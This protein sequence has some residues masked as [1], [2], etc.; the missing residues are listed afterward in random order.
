MGF[1]F[2]RRI[3]KHGLKKALFA[4]LHKQESEGVRLL[5]YHSVDRTGSLLSVTPEKLRA[6][7]S[8]LRQNG[9]RGLSL[10]EFLARLAGEIGGPREVFLTFDDGY[11][12]F[13][14]HAAPLLAEFAFSATVFLVTDYMGDTPLWFRRDRDAINR[15]LDRFVYTQGERTEMEM[16]MSGGETG[17]LMSW[18]QAQELLAQ[19]IDFQSHSSQHRFLTS[20]SSDEL[21]ADLMRSRQRL[22]EKLGVTNELLCYPYGDCNAQVVEAARQTG[23]RAGVLANYHGPNADPF[24]IGRVLLN[25]DTSSVDFQFTL[26]PAIDAYVALRRRVSSVF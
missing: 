10:S 7:L 14:T 9:W 19:G 22:T 15:L 3:L 2:I 21:L 5:A 26:S 16:L 17:R 20:L 1:L 12:N 8:Y 23:F 25:S 18:P 24:R 6:H 4:A 13:Y 11:E